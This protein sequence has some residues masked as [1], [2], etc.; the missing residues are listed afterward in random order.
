MPRREVQLRE[1]RLEP[2]QRYRAAADPVGWQMM[3][4]VVEARLTL[5]LETGRPR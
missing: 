4:F 2:V 3:I 5:E 1:W